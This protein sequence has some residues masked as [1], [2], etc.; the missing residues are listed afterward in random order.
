MRLR[1]LVCYI[2]IISRLIINKKIFKIQDVNFYLSNNRSTRA[3]FCSKRFY[4]EVYLVRDVI[5]TVRSQIDH[6]IDV[7]ANVGTVGLVAEKIG[8]PVTMVEPNREL[9]KA[10]KIN[11]QVNNSKAAILDFALCDV[12]GKSMFYET[13]DDV[14]GSLIDGYANKIYKQYFVQTMRLDT[15]LSDRPSIQSAF[16]KVDV[17]GAE[18]S[19][20]DGLGKNFDRIAAGLIEVKRST[21]HHV[22]LSL[23]SKGYY[24]YQVNYVDPDKFTLYQVT[25]VELTQESFDGDMLFF[26]KHL[27]QHF[28]E[29]FPLSL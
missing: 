20:I 29:F 9:F 2:K 1:S 7:G 18:S 16:I 15:F 13:V 17:E 24:L 4:P 6:F 21:Y 10:L 25:E 28:N 22:S 5:K 26:R 19:L 11:A 3:L 27:H 23:L 12:D 14:T 8:V